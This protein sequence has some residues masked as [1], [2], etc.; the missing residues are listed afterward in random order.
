MGWL[1][2]LFAVHALAPWTRELFAGAGVSGA[3]PDLHLA[4]LCALGLGAPRGASLWL[5][6]ALGLLRATDGVASPSAVVAASCALVALASGLSRAFAAGGP[7]GRLL[8]SAFLCVA[9]ALLTGGLGTSSAWSGLLSVEGI[10]R[11]F[12]TAG[13]VPVVLGPRSGW[14]PR[15]RRSAPRA[16]RAADRPRARL[17]FR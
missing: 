9:W 10:A 17:V 16:R 7:V 15:P 4:A 12:L 5:A 3:C 8:A 14:L 1:L 2:L 13:C 6:L 11:L